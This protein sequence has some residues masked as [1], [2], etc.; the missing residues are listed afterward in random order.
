MRPQLETAREAAFD[1]CDVLPVEQLVERTR[2][3][4]SGGESVAR[5]VDELVPRCGLDPRLGVH[6][7]GAGFLGAESMPGA[8]ALRPSSRR[9]RREAVSVVSWE[10]AAT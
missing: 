9:S 1:R 2:V 4:T 5:R 3:D 7:G 6:V 8:N 10:V